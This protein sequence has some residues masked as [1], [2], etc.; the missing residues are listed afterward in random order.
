[1]TTTFDEGK[2][3]K[4]IGIVIPAFNEEKTIKKVI[5]GAIQYGIP[6]VVDDGSED[7]SLEAIKKFSDKVKIITLFNSG[8]SAARNAG[9]L[10][11]TFS[12]GDGKGYA[13]QL[14][15]CDVFKSALL[16]A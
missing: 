7:S 5:L 11:R 3:I 10:S 2:S 15:R 12:L 16:M 13:R 1:M 4:K 9:V 6:I 8:S 14:Q